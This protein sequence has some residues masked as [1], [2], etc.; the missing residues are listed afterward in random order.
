MYVSFGIFGNILLICFV[1]VPLL[2]KVEQI[3]QQMQTSVLI[4]QY[5]MAIDLKEDFNSKRGLNFLEF[6]IILKILISFGA[7]CEAYCLLLSSV[8]H[9]VFHA[10]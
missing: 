10:H 9:E 1:T 2:G 7:S 4:L 5:A 6:P 8:M 3:S